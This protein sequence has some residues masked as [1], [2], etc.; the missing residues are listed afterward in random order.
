MSG[1]SGRRITVVS[2]LPPPVHGVTIVTGALLHVL[3]EAGAEVRLVDRRFSRTVA[4]VGRFR[5][6]KVLALVGYWFRFLG[7]VIGHRPDA[8]VLFGTTRSFSFPADL[9]IVMIA[10]VLRLPLVNYVHS[11]GYRALA[12]RRGFGRLVAFSLGS[13]DLTV[14]LGPTLISDV[15]PWADG[16]TTRTIYNATARL[17]TPSHRDD[18][19]LLFMSNL[20]AEKGVNDFLELAV[21]LCQRRPSLICELAGAVVEPEVHAEQV[22]RLTALG[23]ERRVR[24]LGVVTG[25]AKQQALA[26]STALIFPSRFPLEAQPLTI[27]E[28]MSVGMPVVAFDTG[29]IRDIVAHEQT[30]MLVAPGNVDELIARTDELLENPALRAS[31]GQGAVERYER[32]HSLE[33][34]QVEWARALTSVLER[35]AS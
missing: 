15:S 34:F 23:L 24:F 35:K 18:A 14:C 25:D 16:G 29:G 3:R 30:G 6:R 1:I 5:M 31:L 28:A 20:I 4:D 33:S 21:E 7:D 2:Q 17:P 11:V 13:A 12:A 27:I 19:R 9:G 26:H 32:L 22:A 10:K 8:V